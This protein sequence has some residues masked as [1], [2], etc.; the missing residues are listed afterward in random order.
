MNKILPLLLFIAIGF[1]EEL[2]ATGNSFAANYIK[3]LDVPLSFSGTYGELRSNHFHSG[4]DMRTGGVTG[5]PVYAVNDGY[6]SRISVSPYGY[7]NALYITHDDGLTSVYGHLSGFSPE[8]ASYVERCQYEKESFAVDL[9]PGKNDF[10]VTRGEIVAWSGN[11]GSSGG[12]HLHF[13]LRDKNNVPMNTLKRGVYKV[14]DNMSP[15]FKDV[16]FYSYSRNNYISEELPKGKQSEVIPVTDCFY[17][18]ADVY[19]RQDGTSAKLGIDRL[20][21][22]LD[23]EL[24]YE[25]RSGEVSFG[26]TRYI[27]SLIDGYAKLA[28][29]RLYLKSMRDPGNKISD[30]CS[31]SGDGLVCISDSAVHKIELIAWDESGNTSYLSY[32]VKR[33]FNPAE[34]YRQPEPE[35]QADGVF[36]FWMIPNV[37]IGDSVKVYFPDGAMYNSMYLTVTEGEK[38]ADGY[39]VVTIGNPAVLLH[40]PMKVSIRTDVPERYRNKAVLARLYRGRK[41]YAGG[42]YRDG[43]VTGNGSYF[44]KYTIAVDTIAPVV[45]ALANYG[46]V[47]GLRSMKFRIRD[48]FSGIRSFRAEI[49]GKWVLATF[50]A[51]T[52]TLEIPLASARISG[53]GERQLSIKVEDMVGNVAIFRKRI[54]F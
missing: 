38:G 37:Y 54:I 29:G 28:T 42:S 20:Q 32:R 18:A 44:G 5:L 52:A 50:D 53:S 40:K 31:Y 26:D 36:M 24:F 33:R 3:P 8:L 1:A 34:F 35:R 39:P 4:V 19:D 41:I 47:R 2:S 43:E 25:Y 23:G 21:M 12:P 49:D 27:N 51:K 22:L 7:G 30:M 15:Y 45:N 46:N 11:S 10:R 16:K 14:K 17:V 9:Y 6:V 48:E 13:E